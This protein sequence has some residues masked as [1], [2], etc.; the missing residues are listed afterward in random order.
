MPHNL[1]SQLKVDKD[2]MKTNFEEK[3]GEKN[4]R[5][6]SVSTLPLALNKSVSNEKE[7]V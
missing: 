4:Q 7:V 6:A 3:S 2:L 5:E 1:S